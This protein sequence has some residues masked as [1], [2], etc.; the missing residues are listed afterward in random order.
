MKNNKK[1]EWTLEDLRDIVEDL[2]VQIQ[3]L[4]DE[5]WDHMRKKH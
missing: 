2:Q 4:D 5:F 3:T 1:S